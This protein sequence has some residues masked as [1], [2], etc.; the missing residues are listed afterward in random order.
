MEKQLLLKILV[1]LLIFIGESF[2]LYA[3]VFSAVNAS[4]KVF[5]FKDYILSVF[6]ALVGA[7]IF[8]GAIYI[9]FFSLGNIWI[10]GAISISAI[11]IVQPLL[12]YFIFDYL[13]KGFALVSMI[14]AITA[15]I[16]SLFE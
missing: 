1:I 11:V 10:L 14:L 13:P 2:Y 6:I 3:E 16:F 15:L 8:L 9:G 7:I 4:K 12:A 5:Q